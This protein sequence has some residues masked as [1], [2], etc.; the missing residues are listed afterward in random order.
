MAFN[1]LS[2]TNAKIQQIE[3]KWIAMEAKGF[4]LEQRVSDIQ[5]ATTK[6]P[7]LEQEIQKLKIHMEDLENRNRRNNLR[8]YGLPENIE[9]SDMVPFLQKLLP[10]LLDLHSSSSPLN[11]QRAHR[12]GRLLPSSNKPRGIIMLF[13]EFTELMQVLRAVRLKRRLVW[14]GHNIYISQDVSNATNA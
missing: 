8:L 4:D 9:G 2:S 3:E 7:L 12:L 6:I 13:L 10:E 1:R 5:D 11:I 14:S